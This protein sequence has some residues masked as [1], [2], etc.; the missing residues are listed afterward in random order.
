MK[1]N[2]YDLSIIV[3]D[4]SCMHIA[5]TIYEW[6]YFINYFT[7][8]LSFNLCVCAVNRRLRWKLLQGANYKNICLDI[9][10]SMQWTK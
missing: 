2:Y 9:L 3:L 8:S 7:E 1:K 4:A 10:P 6:N 5:Y